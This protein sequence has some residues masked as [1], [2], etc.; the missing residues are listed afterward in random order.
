MASEKFTVYEELHYGD[1]DTE[2]GV[3]NWG[4]NLYSRLPDVSGVVAS[5]IGTASNRV[6]ARA[7]FQAW[8]KE[9]MPKYA[10]AESRIEHKTLDIVG[11]GTV[12]VPVK[13]YLT[14]EELDAEEGD[15]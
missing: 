12:V 7:A 2:D 8:C 5:V 1:A 3:C 9:E 13:V 11:G 4:G 14:Q 15:K 10:Y 6:E